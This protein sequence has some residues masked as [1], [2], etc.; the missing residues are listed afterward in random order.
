MVADMVQNQPLNELFVFLQY[1]KHSDIIAEALRR[2]YNIVCY[3]FDG[4]VPQSK[5]GQIQKD[6]AGPDNLASLLMTAGAGSVSLNLT[7]AKIMIQT[8]QWWNALVEFQAV[9]RIWRQGQ[10][11]KATV[12]K[13]TLRKLRY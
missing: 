9:C 2:K 8:K 4:T 10:K 6:F 7:I 3:R 12:I 13:V 1:L 5:R 11:D